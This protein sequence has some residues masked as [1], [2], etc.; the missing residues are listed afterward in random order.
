[1]SRRNNISSRVELTLESVRCFWGSK[2]GIPPLREVAL[3]SEG[4]LATNQP[5]HYHQMKATTLNTHTNYSSLGEGDRRLEG[6]YLPT[7]QNNN[8]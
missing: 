7:N 2:G 8:K 6:A 1:M 5:K 3:R 4:V